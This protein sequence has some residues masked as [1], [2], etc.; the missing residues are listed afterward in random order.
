MSLHTRDVASLAPWLLSASP[1][2]RLC[3]SFGSSWLSPGIT[4]HTEGLPGLPRMGSLNAQIRLAQPCQPA[5][6]RRVA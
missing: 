3:L 2:Q 4:A 6:P 1:A 5:V